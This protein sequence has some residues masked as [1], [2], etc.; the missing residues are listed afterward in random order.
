M[1]KARPRFRFITATSQQCQP[2]KSFN[3][4]YTRTYQSQMHCRCYG[5]LVSTSKEESYALRCDRLCSIVF[6]VVNDSLLSS[7]RSIRPLKGECLCR[8]C[9]LRA[10][11]L[12]VVD[13]AKRIVAVATGA[14][15]GRMTTDAGGLELL[16][17]SR[18]SPWYFGGIGR[19]YC[20]WS[21]LWFDSLKVQSRLPVHG[22]L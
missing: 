10:D 1:T 5:R 15:A 16:V 12:C 4:R 18:Y 17:S 19:C 20:H 7:I 13:T 8:K 3:F 22:W 14:T 21:W 9:W 6:F 2:I 11:D